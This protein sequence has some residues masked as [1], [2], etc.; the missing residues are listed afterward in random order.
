MTEEN[1]AGSKCTSHRLCTKLTSMK[2]V[3]YMCDDRTTYATFRTNKTK[4][5]TTRIL[6]L[7]WDN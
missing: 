3:A 1:K 6:R 7:T 2:S 5:F 4:R